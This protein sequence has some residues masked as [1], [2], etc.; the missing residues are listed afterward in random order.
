MYIQ[1]SSEQKIPGDEE[2][3]KNPLGIM[4]IFENYSVS[5]SVS[6]TNDKT[7]KNKYI[8]SCIVLFSCIAPWSLKRTA[9]YKVGRLGIH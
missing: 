4:D 6:F 5:K 1:D 9:I 3:N 2:S 8:L 7:K